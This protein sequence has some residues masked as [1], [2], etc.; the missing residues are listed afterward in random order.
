M[1]F[2]MKTRQNNDVTNC[3]GTVY[4]ENEIELS[5]SIKKGVDNDKIQLGQWRDWLYNCGLRKKTKLNCHDR[6]DWVW[7]MTKTK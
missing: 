3:T 1:Q 2:V 6:L 4:A 5:R 7:S